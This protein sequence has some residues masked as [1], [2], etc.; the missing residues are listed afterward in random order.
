MN[1]EV[2]SIITNLERVLS[3]QPWY[4]EAV[5]PML[6][7]IHP[8]VVYINPKNSH[9]AIEIL[10]HMITWAEFCLNRVQNKKDYD[11]KEAEQMDWR[12]IDPKQHTWEKGLNEFE[13]IHKQLV[14][15]LQT[16][17]DAFLSEMVDY[18]EYNFRF[19][20]NGLIQHNIYHLGQIAFL[21]NLL[22]E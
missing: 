21:K 9:A 15:E 22:G 8:A 20:L 4:G 12:I 11:L 6:R 16:K 13:Q 19:L 10:Y 2:Q 7:K 1:K 14:A 18:R 3:G 17:D 5:M